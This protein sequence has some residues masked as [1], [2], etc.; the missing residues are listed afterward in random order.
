MTKQIA[1][2]KNYNKITLENGL[3]I[4][5]IPQKETK[6]VTILVLVGTGSKYE[7][8][9]ISGV[10]HFLEHMFFKGTKKR[11]TPTEIAEFLDRLG[12]DYNAFTGEEMTGYY[13]KVEA[14][15][16]KEALDWVADI[17]LHSTLP[18]QEI[19]KERGVIIEEIKMYEDN[20]MRYIGELWKELLY[21]DQPAGWDI[22]GTRKTV[23]QIKRE[24]LLK[25]MATQYVAKNTII[26]V[27]GNFQE[28]EAIS[29]V[30]NQFLNI[31]TGTYKDK[32]K[33]NECQTKP[34]T[35]LL[36]KDIKQTHIALGVRAYNIFHPD[37]FVL[38]ILAIL[39]GG[40]MS[41]R[42]FNKVREKLGAAYYVR[43]NY[44][45]DT[46]TGEV[47]T[48]TGVDNAKLEKVIKTILQ[49][50]KKITKEKIGAAELKKVKDCYKG[51]LILGLESSDDKASFYATQ[52]LLMKNILTP[53]Q[54]IEKIE[55][56]T[57]VDIQ[58]VA[59]DIFVPEKLNF[60]ILGKH[61]DDKL[62]Q[63]LLHF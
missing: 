21:G 11:K 1:K 47:V 42:L 30:K 43:T 39:L 59:R 22:A 52:E 46:D 24:D 10:S 37:R 13:A 26:C 20:P 41:S 7:T 58:R 3:R 17:F 36:Y 14:N 50:Y 2:Q 23:S 15:H 31:R 29:K 63:K 9:N 44:E 28:Q 16:F 48:F 35:K 62:F 25:Y 19:E 38:D 34:Q 45:S 51:R 57:A 12:G 53:E 18:I 40:M 56:I 6:A 32:P 5:T 4:I 27:S 60:A 33:V 8:K 54:I 55:K 61:K 49:E